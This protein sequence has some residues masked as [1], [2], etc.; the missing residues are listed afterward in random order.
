MVV[1]PEGEDSR[2]RGVVY[3]C[4]LGEDEGVELL[5]FVM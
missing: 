2:G 5:T 4:P 1:L 3:V